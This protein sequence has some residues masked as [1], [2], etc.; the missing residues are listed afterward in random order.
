MTATGR[1]SQF[2]TIVKQDELDQIADFHY[3]QILTEG[4]TRRPSCPTA[5]CCDDLPTL[6]F[7][8]DRSCVHTPVLVDTAELCGLNLFQE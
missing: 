3:W 1:Q 2:K 4:P 8:R 7:V 6:I 5:S